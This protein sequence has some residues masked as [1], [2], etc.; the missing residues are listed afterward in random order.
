MT[1]RCTVLKTFVILALDNYKE[2]T[3]FCQICK[4]SIIGPSFLFPSFRSI[5]SK[6]LSEVFFFL[7]YLLRDLW[8]LK[9]NIQRRVIMPHAQHRVSFAHQ[10]KPCTASFLEYQIRIPGVVTNP[11]F[12]FFFFPFQ[13]D[14][15]DGWIS[16]RSYVMSFFFFLFVN[17]FVQIITPCPYSYWKCVFT[18]LYNK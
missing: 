17:Y 12:F 5:F 7:C 9:R 14:I 18:L 2:S 4:A 13:C 6:A 10:S 3:Y 11:F 16:S 1:R 15:S 8:N